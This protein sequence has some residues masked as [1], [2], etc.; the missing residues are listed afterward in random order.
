[1]PVGGTRLRAHG[2]RNNSGTPSQVT[3]RSRGTGRVHDRD[4]H[5]ALTGA[6]DSTLQKQISALT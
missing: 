5:T 1:M 4:P 6:P 3:S 2:G